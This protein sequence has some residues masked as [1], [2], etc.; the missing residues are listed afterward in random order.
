[1]TLLEKLKKGLINGFNAASDITSEYTKIGR[2]KIDILGIK[3]EIE[4]KMLELG[5]R[6]YDKAINSD[7]FNFKDEQS[8]IDIIDQIKKLENELKKCEE[9][10][11]RINKMDETSFEKKN[12]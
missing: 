9:D 7:T 10:I 6:I 4:E 11:N 2:I 8:V 5:G 3:K 1:M 12:K